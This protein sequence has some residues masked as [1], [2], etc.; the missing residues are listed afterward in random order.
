MPSVPNRIVFLPACLAS[1]PNVWAWVAV[2]H[3]STVTVSFGF[4]CE[5]TSDLIALASVAP[6]SVPFSVW[7][8][9][10]IPAFLKT[11]IITLT[12]PWE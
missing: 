7:W 2:C 8:L 3:G 1:S 9:T 12:R 10:V 4:S 6:V 5:V 11:G